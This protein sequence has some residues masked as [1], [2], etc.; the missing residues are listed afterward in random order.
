MNLDFEFGFDTIYSY[1]CILGLILY[2]A[3]YYI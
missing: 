3:I 2:I 1:I